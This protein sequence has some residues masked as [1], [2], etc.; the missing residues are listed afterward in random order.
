MH[1]IWLKGE[2]ATWKMQWFLQLSDNFCLSAWEREKKHTKTHMLWD[3]V[4]LNKWD[5]HGK[6][7]CGINLLWNWLTVPASPAWVTVL[8]QSF[9]D[10]PGIPEGVETPTP[11]SNV[12]WERNTQHPYVCMYSQVQQNKQASIHTRLWT[13]S[14]LCILSHTGGTINWS[15][16]LLLHVSIMKLLSDVGG[17]MINE[18]RETNHRR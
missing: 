2:D 10:L 1:L 6:S 14:D 11:W 4:K 12:T 16:T 9:G 18:S 15:A 13:V 7:V 17:A 8:L 3:G 5:F